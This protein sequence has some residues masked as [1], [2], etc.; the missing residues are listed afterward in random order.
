[1]T[2]FAKDTPVSCT[3]S[4]K[5]SQIFGF[6]ARRS[7]DSKKYG[8]I[9]RLMVSQSER[10]ILADRQLTDRKTAQRHLLKIQNNVII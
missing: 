6:P 10:A 8:P 2:R 7:R 1:M 4:K 9:C 5:F 3:W